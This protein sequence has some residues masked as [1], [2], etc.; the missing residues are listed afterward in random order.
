MEMHFDELLEKVTSFIQAEAKTE[1]IVGDPFTLGDFNCV[2][3]MKVGMGFGSGGGEGSAP[4][5]GKGMGGGAGGGVGLAPIG[6]LVSNG[7][8]ISFIS[9]E[10]HKGLSALF[11][12]VPDLIEKLIDKKY[13]SE[14]ATA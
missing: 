3:V 6:F 8:Q 9:A 1:T 10:T 2:P 7:G 5:Q 13:E 14:G 12:K 4:K 11:E